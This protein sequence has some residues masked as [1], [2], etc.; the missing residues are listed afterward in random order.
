MIIYY[1]EIYFELPHSQSLKD[2]RKVLRSLKD[3]VKN[4]YNVA[5]LENDYQDDHAYV[6]L[7]IVT[8]SLYQKQADKTIDQIVQ[9]IESHYEVDFLTVHKERR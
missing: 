8:L 3:K 4:H 2:K 9:L 5:L 6:S 1:A 7:A